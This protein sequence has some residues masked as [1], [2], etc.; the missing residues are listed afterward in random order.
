M[1]ISEI[2]VKCHANHI[3]KII[4]EQDHILG[5]RTICE[6]CYFDQEAKRKAFIQET[7]EREA[8]E[9]RERQ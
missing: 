5:L 1:I 9:A 6:T 7:T 3:F 2:T 8:K 4:T